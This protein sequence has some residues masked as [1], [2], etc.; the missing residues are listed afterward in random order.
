MQYE[1][2]ARFPWLQ[3]LQF[4]GD[5]TLMQFLV[6]RAFHKAQPVWQQQQQQERMQVMLPQSFGRL[7]ARHQQQAQQ[8]QQQQQHHQEQQQQQQQQQRIAKTLHEAAV[9]I[10]QCAQDAASVDWDRVRVSPTPNLDPCDTLGGVNAPLGPAC[11]MPQSSRRNYGRSSLSSEG[12]A[13]VIRAAV[14]TKLEPET[15]GSSPA[16]SKGDLA[17]SEGDLL[18]DKGRAGH[19]DG[20]DLVGAVPINEGKGAAGEVPQQGKCLSIV[21]APG[22]NA[23]QRA[24]PAGI[25]LQCKYTFA[26]L[27]Q[28][29]MQKSCPLSPALCEHI[30]QVT[31]TEERLQLPHCQSVKAQK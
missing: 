20:R 23:F 28:Q 24:I 26:A 18:S 16:S 5:F 29:N 17:S 19:V 7:A 12:H 27:R 10:R 3:P 8:Q 14:E 2:L 11:S 22:T 9:W 21:C 31:V 1:S 25:S 4:G 15:L 13:A 30:C 6:A